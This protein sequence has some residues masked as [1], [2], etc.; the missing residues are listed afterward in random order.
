MM[1]GNPGDDGLPAGLDQNLWVTAKGYEGR[2][3]L[4]W[5][6]HL[7]NGPGRIG[8]WSS[9][10]Q[11][12]TRIS[13]SD[14]L[15]SS[16]ESVFWIDAFLIGSEPSLEYMFGTE[17]RED[18]SFDAKSDRWQQACEEYRTSG[19]WSGGRWFTPQPIEDEAQLP[20]YVYLRRGDEI[21]TWKDGNW[22]FEYVHT[23]NSGDLIV[24]SFCFE[25]GSHDFL[26][27]G[28][29]FQICSDCGYAMEIHWEK[30]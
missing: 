8:A 6:P 24:G 11:S 10:H 20:P 19:K 12:G 9:E 30:G 21:W 17:I 22:T 16:P 25:R 7:N 14:I 26:V 28:G 27:S 13:K 1:A 15:L 2:L 23:S 18:P 3:Y 4:G 5:N 29:N